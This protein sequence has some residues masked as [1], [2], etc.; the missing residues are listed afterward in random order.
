MNY[1]HDS[2]F[3][4]IAYVG[5][6]GL[7]LGSFINVVI[8]RLPKILEQRWHDEAAELRG[9]TTGN[10]PKLSLSTPRSRCPHCGHK[11]SS[12]E[13][14]PVLSYLL[15]R[16]RC[17]HCKAPISLRYPAIEL[18]TAALSVAVA[19]KFGA[20]T[21]TIAGLV[22]TWVLIALTFIDLDTFLLPDDLTIPLLWV[23]L[24]FNVQSTFVPLDQA[25]LGAIAGYLS[26]WSVYWL[27]KLLTGKEGMGYGDFK[28]LAA[29]GAFLGWQALPGVILL[30]SLVGACLGIGLIVFAKHGR[31]TPIPF[32][33]YLAI[34]GLV[35]LFYGDSLRQLFLPA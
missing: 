32:G 18:L 4:F 24:A 15:L 19:C 10:E 21:Q 23:G 29:I 2:P 14:I 3:L 1:F 16:G 28:L 11:I 17:G 26:L 7:C 22:F 25:V 33:P 5:L 9:E 20:N 12:L 34:A 6:I 30:S 35:T 13:N 31:E 27:F 8:H